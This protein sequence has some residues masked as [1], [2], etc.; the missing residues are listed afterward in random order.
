M[1]MAKFPSIPKNHNLIKPSSF[2][3][4]KFYI[5]PDKKVSVQN[6]PILDFLQVFTNT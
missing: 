1:L 6:Y 5:S 4:F 3:L 2:L